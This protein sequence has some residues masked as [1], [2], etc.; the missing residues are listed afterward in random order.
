M[1]RLLLYTLLIFISFP[2]LAQKK[3]RVKKPFGRTTFEGGWTVSSNGNN[4]IL[5]PSVL[6]YWAVDKRKQRFKFGFGGRV[7]SSYGNSN[8]EYITARAEL[9]SGKTGPSVFFADQVEEN[10][11]TLSIASTRIHAAN[12][13]LALRYEFD[14]RF[15][16]E[17]NIDL[18]GVSFGKRQ[19]AVLQ[20]DDGKSQQLNAYPTTG[21]VLLISDND[22]GTLNSEL[23][24]SYLHK[25]RLRFKI[26]GVFLFNEYEVSNPPVYVNSTGTVIDAQRFRNKSLQLGIGLNYIFNYYL[27]KNFK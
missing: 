9:T 5:S 1:K 18:A 15:G 24:F 26:G 6:Q 19:D 23:M 3:L 2:T 17:F 14:K 12:I 25:S 13:F 16:V 27:S 10:I 21:N 20:Y 7:S 11:D 4:T 8:L 22:I